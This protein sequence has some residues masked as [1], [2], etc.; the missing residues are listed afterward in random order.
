[1][2]LAIG[3][4]ASTT[5]DVENSRN[6]KN[7]KNQRGDRVME[8]TIQGTTQKSFWRNE[9]GLTLIELL[10]VIVILAII[11]AIAIPSVSGI[12]NK[13]KDK[14][15]IANAHLI[16]DAA[17]NKFSMENLVPNA[18]VT[19]ETVTL[20][21]LVDEGYLEQAPKDPKA[22]NTTY[23]GTGTGTVTSVTAT[24]TAGTTAGTSI[25]SYTINLV[26]NDGTAYF[27]AK[28]EKDL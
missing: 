15:E 14:T 19:S 25:V 18:T 2:E 26:A 1:M 9:K 13:S 5:Q 3:N 28:A 12:I 16:I 27:T 7:Q 24:Y 21:Q 4:I 8:M 10:A 23:L 20:Q 22:A 17:R 6:Q 11:A